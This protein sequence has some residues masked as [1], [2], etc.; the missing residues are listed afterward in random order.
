MRAALREI[1]VFLKVTFLVW[2]WMPMVEKIKKIWW[3]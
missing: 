3:L 2:V 1:Y